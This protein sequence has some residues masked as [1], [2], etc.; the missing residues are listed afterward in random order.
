MSKHK[1]SV[2]INIS[3]GM[4]LYHSDYNAYYH[5]ICKSYRVSF[6]LCMYSKNGYYEIDEFYFGET[7][8]SEEISVISSVLNYA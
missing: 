4:L 8:E 6:W 1:S 7:I 5:V 2:C 3:P